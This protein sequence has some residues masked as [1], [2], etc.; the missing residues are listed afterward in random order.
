MSAG[1]TDS[2]SGKDVDMVTVD[3]AY[4]DKGS[5]STDNFD[6]AVA[7]WQMKDL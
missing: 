6:S 3:A 5:V 2:S 4:H 7:A 1:T